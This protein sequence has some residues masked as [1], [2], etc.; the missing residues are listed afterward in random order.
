MNFSELTPIERAAILGFELRGGRGFSAAEVAQLTD[1]TPSG[2]RRVL[3][4]ISRVLP[5]CKEGDVWRVIQRE[6][7]DGE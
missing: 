3:S 2:A 7:Q 5:L 6:G 1:I 4:Q